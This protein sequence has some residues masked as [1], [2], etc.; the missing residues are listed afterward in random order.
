MKKIISFMLALVITESAFSQQL[1]PSP[2][3]TKQDYLQKSKQQKTAAWVL[4]GG[5][6]ALSSIGAIVAAPKA[7]EDIGYVALLLPN[8]IVGNPQPEP[9]NDYTA[10]TILIIGGTAAMLSSIP[11][12][13]ASGKN[14]RKAMSLSFKNETVPQLYKSSLVYNSIPSLTLKFKL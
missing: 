7:A 5:G 13:I 10:E 2:T 14:K 8:I 9:Q 6:F 11:L 4:L 3:F 1:T 12:F